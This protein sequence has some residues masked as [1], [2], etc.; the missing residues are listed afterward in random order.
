MRGDA[1]MHIEDSLS[2]ALL[3]SVIDFA[4]SFV[5]IGG[6]GLLLSMLPLINKLGSIK[7]ENLKK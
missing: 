2:G 3:I 7:D 1:I 4:L 6:I 5:F